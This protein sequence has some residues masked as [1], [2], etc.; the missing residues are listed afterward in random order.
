GDNG[1]F[2]PAISADGRFVAIASNATNLVGGDTNGFTDIFVRDRKTGKTRRVSLS[3]AGAQGD[4]GS[5]EPSISADGGFVAFTS[6]AT[7]LVGGDTNGFEDVFV[8]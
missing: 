7:N 2:R 6:E 1:S 5:F 8:R 4:S 3:S